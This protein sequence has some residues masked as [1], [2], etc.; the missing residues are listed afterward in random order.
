LVHAHFY[1]VFHQ[2]SKSRGLLI[3][4]EDD[5]AAAKSLDTFTLAFAP[6]VAPFIPPRGPVVEPVSTVVCEPVEAVEACA[7]DPPAIDGRSNPRP[8]PA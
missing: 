3:D 2:P 6:A 5:H 4:D 7:H 8:P 1:H